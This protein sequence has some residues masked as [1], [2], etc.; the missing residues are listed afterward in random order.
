MRSIM[1]Q[2]KRNI[3]TAWFDGAAQMD[4][5][6]CGAGGVIKTPYLMVYKWLFNCGRGTNNRA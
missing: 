5:Q 3:I 2:S 1:I 6:I 4:G